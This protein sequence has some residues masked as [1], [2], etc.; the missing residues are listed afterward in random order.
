MFCF[1]DSYAQK[2]SRSTV[3]GGC[4]HP[5]GKYNAWMQR[6][7]GTFANSY[8]RRA[9]ITGKKVA[10]RGASVFGLYDDCL[11]KAATTC[12]EVEGDSFKVTLQLVV[13]TVVVGKIEQ[14][15]VASFVGEGHPVTVN[16]LGLSLSAGNADNLNMA[17]L[18]DEYYPTHGARI[19]IPFP[20]LP[21][22]SS[23]FPSESFICPT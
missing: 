21:S 2:S 12:A 10:P 23:P 4:G 5:G 7:C 9:S 16:I 8:Y 15:A 11:G 17:R 20:S 19:S 1:F 13:L 6:R 3:G 22:S 14:E 18:A